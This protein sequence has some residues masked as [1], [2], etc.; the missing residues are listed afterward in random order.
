MCG[1][2]IG[3]R[4]KAWKIKSKLIELD[5]D[6]EEDQKQEIIDREAEAMQLFFLANHNRLDNLP[7]HDESAESA[8]EGPAVKAARCRK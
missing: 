3:A 5:S 2:H 7:C 1:A 8:P 6:T 4:K